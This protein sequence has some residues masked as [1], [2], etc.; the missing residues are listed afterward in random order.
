MAGGQQF[1]SRA[2]AEP[3]QNYKTAL[4]DL[5]DTTDAL[6]ELMLDVK[7]L[8]DRDFGAPDSLDADLEAGFF[9]SFRSFVLFIYLFIRL[10]LFL[11]YFYFY[12]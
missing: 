7:H 12:L 1:L 3:R 5:E 11:F 4:S 9:P 2:G 10:F 8:G 6:D